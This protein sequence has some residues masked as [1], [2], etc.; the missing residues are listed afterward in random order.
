MRPNPSLICAPAASILGCVV[1]VGLV[2]EELHALAAAASGLRRLGARP[3]IARAATL[4]T[5]VLDQYRA[6]KQQRRV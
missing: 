5:Q 4:E 2:A 3:L 6:L 1:V